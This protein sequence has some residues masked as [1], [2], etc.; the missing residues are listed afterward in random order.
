MPCQRTEVG[1]GV[2]LSLLNENIKC[3]FL[4]QSSIS[5]GRLVTG[6]SLPTRPQHHAAAAAAAAAAA[7][8]SLLI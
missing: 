8:D 6:R 5:G 3:S 2:M 1:G 4:T 7:I